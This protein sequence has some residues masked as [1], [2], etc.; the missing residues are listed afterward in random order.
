MSK[1]IVVFG[2]FNKLP[3]RTGLVICLTS[4]KALEKWQKESIKAYSS[5][6]LVAKLFM[7][8]KI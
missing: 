4:G 2:L 7:K 3:L 1:A 6:L 8:K 5:C